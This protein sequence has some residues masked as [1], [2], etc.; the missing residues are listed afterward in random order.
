MTISQE[1][2]QEKE[3]LLRKLNDLKEII[4]NSN[5]MPEEDVSLY[6][7]K[8]DRVMKEVENEKLKLVFLEAF[9]LGNLL[10]LAVLLK[11]SV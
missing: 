7:E 3:I 11:I 2:T 9:H 4:K 5:Y 10:F 8:I 1:F 6:M